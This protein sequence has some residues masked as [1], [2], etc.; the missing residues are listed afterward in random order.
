APQPGMD[1][2]PGEIPGQVQKLYHTHL[3][4]AEHHPGAPRFDPLGAP[5]GDGDQGP[6]LPVGLPPQPAGDRHRGDR[7]QPDGR[8]PAPLDAR[9]ADLGHSSLPSTASHMSR[10]SNASAANMVTIPTAAKATAPALGS[11]A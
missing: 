11:T 10:G 6:A 1:L 9:L 4:V 7:H 8:E 5:E 2:D 3:D